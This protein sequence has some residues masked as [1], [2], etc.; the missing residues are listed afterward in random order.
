[1][2][3]NT[4]DVLAMLYLL[5]VPH[6]QEYPVQEQTGTLVL[7]FLMSYEIIFKNGLLF[8]FSVLVI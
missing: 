1:M 2:A 5:A 8:I 3:K 4:L 6:Q 7:L